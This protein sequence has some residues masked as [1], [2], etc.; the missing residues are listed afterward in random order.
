MNLTWTRAGL[1]LLGVLALGAGIVVSGIVPVGASSDHWPITRWLLDF[2][3]SRSVAT[4]SMGI[5]V[6]DLEDPALVMRGAG[7]Y[8]LGCSPC[9]GRPGRG[10]SEVALEMTPPP[11]LLSEVLHLWDP[12]ELFYIV[13]HGVKFTS[14]PAWPVAGR[15]DEVWAMVA[16]LERLSGMDERTYRRLALGDAAEP[17]PPADLL[18]PGGSGADLDTCAR[19]HGLDGRGRGAGAFPSLAGQSRAYLAS[20]LMAFARGER[21]SG[22]MHVVAAPLDASTVAELAAYFEQQGSGGDVLLSVPPAAADRS[23]GARPGAADLGEQLARRGLP[24]LKVPS[25][26]ACHGPADHTRN[27]A[28]P[29]LAGQYGRYLVDQLRLFAA[30]QRGGAELAHLMHS[31]V[32]QMSGQQMEDVA[33][34]YSSLG[35][36]LF[37]AA[38]R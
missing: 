18:R 9:H 29:L 26:V 23:A 32:R 1:A 38:E 6:P 21:R 25:C 10:R 17:S 8:E 13:R 36:A 4:H 35:G 7:H 16:F 27:P 15:D 33:A 14:M 28:Y 37:Q 24:E 31:A 20:S 22:T 12:A 11:P 30:G 5:D 19:C 34:Y 3:M 2:A